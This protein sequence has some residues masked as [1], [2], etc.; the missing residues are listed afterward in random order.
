MVKSTFSFGGKLLTI[1]LTIVIFIALCAG[2][3]I[4]AV[5]KV[6]VRT[7]AGWIGMQD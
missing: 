1:F 3:L 6:K 2:S 4:L 7:L 5:T